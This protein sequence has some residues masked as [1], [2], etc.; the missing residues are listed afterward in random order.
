MKILLAMEAK[1]ILGV[2]QKREHNL[3]GGPMSPHYCKI[4]FHWKLNP[5][6]IDSHWQIL[7]WKGTLKA[8]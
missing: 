8:T 6:T 2:F 7:Q 4:I 5:A 3:F 1:C